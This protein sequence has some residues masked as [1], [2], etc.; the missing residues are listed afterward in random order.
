MAVGM[1]AHGHL[2]SLHIRDV[3][4]LIMMAPKGG[5][6][7]SPNMYVVKIKMC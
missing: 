3:L 4:M 2:T 5:N 6:T 7:V 1:E